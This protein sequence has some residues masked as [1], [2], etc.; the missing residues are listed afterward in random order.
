M[1]N[2]IIDAAGY[3][4]IGLIIGYGIYFYGTELFR[5]ISENS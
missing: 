4:M 3:T 1:L 5:I 2:K